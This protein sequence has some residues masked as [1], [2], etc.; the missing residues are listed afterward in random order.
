MDPPQQAM[1]C[2][3]TRPHCALGLWFVVLVQ[4]CPTWHE[5]STGEEAAGPRGL[6]EEATLLLL[7]SLHHS[8]V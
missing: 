8:A 3:E 2:R 4:F 1:I 7:P 6:K 5:L